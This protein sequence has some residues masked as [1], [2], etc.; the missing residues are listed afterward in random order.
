M[1]AKKIN[2]I[3]INKGFIIKDIIKFNSV[4]LNKFIK[5]YIIDWG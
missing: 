1:L 2:K 3:K 4:P 5:L